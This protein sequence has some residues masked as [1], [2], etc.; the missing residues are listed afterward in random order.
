MSPESSINTKRHSQ[1][2]GWLLQLAS[3][4]RDS[5]WHICDYC[6]NIS[7]TAA[8]RHALFGRFYRGLWRAVVR[9]T[10]S[11]R[12][13]LCY[14]EIKPSICTRT[15]NACWH[16]DSKI[17]QNI[18]HYFRNQRDI[19]MEACLTLQ[20]VDQLISNNGACFQSC[21]RQ[22]K[23]PLCQSALQF[24][25]AGFQCGSSFCAPPLGGWRDGC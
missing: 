25:L 1:A 12:T 16:R 20:A 24:P 19:Q 14:S 17:V 3:R 7:S 8:P 11:D 9:I 21:W 2:A 13:W 6:S 4:C 23:S 18:S 10:A 5:E 15:C 22:L